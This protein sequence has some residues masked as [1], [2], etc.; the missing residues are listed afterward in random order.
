MLL[1]FTIL[2]YSL[3]PSYKFSLKGFTLFYMAHDT[4]VLLIYVLVA[5][6]KKQQTLSYCL[7]KGISLE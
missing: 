4:Y 1:F 6:K 5:K 3:Y 2:I 7:S